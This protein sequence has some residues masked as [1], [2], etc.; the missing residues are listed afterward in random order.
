MTTDT[1]DTPGT[2]APPT[3]RRPLWRGVLYIAAAAGVLALVGGSLAVANRAMAEQ[4]QSSFTANGIRELVIDGDAGDVNLVAGTLGGQVQVTT[5]R[6]WAWREPDSSHTVENG[7]LSLTADCPV[8]SFGACDVDQRV[9]VPP[10]ITVRIATSAGSIHA[11]DLQLTSLDVE[12][13]A[14]NIRADGVVV[15]NFSAGTSAGNIDA[16]FAGQAPEHVTARSSAG[17]VILTV[18]EAAYDVDADTSAG[19]VRIEVI[20]DPQATRSISAHTSAGDVIIRRR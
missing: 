18:P 4:D 7:V 9:T 6:S 16:I 13:E 3:G 2:T 10:G 14:G 17:S 15:P 19:Q 11:A 8:L 1:H 5:T 12:T 20:D